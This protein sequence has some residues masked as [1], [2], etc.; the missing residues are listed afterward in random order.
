MLERIYTFEVVVTGDNTKK[1][2]LNFL[3]WD[4]NLILYV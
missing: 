1:R 3:E 2:E 4:I